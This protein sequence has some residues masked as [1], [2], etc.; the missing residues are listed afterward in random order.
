MRLTAEQQTNFIDLLED[1]NN[2]HGIFTSVRS[3]SGRGMYGRQCVAISGEYIN[4]F[5]VALLLAERAPLHGIDVIDIPVPDTD[6][7]GRGIVV[8]WPQVEWPEGRVEFDE[9]EDEWT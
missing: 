7:L 5:V 9:E 1:V 4:P 8:Y 2:H 6:S 3:Y